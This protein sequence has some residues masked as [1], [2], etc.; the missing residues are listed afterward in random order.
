MFLVDSEEVDAWPGTSV[1]SK[2]I[3][4]TIDLFATAS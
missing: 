2:R 4:D 1:P 3:V